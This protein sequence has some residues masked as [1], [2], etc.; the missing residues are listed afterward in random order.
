ML[1]ELK[2][3]TR[4]RFIAIDFDYPVAEV[5]TQIIAH[6]AGVA[7]PLASS[8]AQ[9]ASRLRN[10]DEIGF[11][12]GPSTRLMIY[13]GRLIRRGIPEREACETAIVQA[14]TDDQAVQDGVREIV[15]SA[16]A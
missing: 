7:E 11:L 14:V 4:Q 6:E 9:L 8:L 13:A 2:H 10:L 5:E 15:A 16:F 1:K 12:E 3:S